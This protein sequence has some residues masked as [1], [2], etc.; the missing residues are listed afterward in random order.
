MPLQF[1]NPIFLWGALAGAIPIL[2]H[3]IHR[4][5]TRTVRFAMLDFILHSQKKIARKFH[6]KE[7]VLLAI[8]T[9]LVLGLVGLGAHP[10]LSGT[11]DPALSGGGPTHLVVILDSSMSMSFVEGGKERLSTAKEWAKERLRSLRRTQVAVLSTEPTEQG[12]PEFQ[13][14]PSALSALD[15]VSPSHQVADILGAFRRAYGLLRSVSGGEKEILFLTDGA[16]T[17]W[18]PFSVGNLKAVDPDVRVRLIRFGKKEADPNAAILSLRLKEERV[19]RGVAATLLVRVK[20]FGPQ[21]L[22]ELVLEL[23]AGGRKVGE[24]ALRLGPGGEEE[25]AFEA[26]F[27]EAGELAATVRLLSDPLAGDNTHHFVL[28]VREPPRVLVVDG[29]PRTSLLGSETFYLMNALAP[30]GVAEAPWFRVN[31]VTLEGLGREDLRG[32]DAVI[33][34]NA[35]EVPG[36]VRMALGEFVRGGGGLLF[37]LGERV[38]PEGYNRDFGGGEPDLLPG[39][40]LGLRERGG[41]SPGGVGEVAVRHPALRAFEGLGLEAFSGVRVWRYFALEEREG[42]QILLRLEG[43]SPLLMERSLGKGRVMVFA[44]TADRDWNDLCIR[45]PYL[46]FIQNLLLYLGCRACPGGELP[47][48]LAEGLRVGEVKEIT[49]AR[50]LAGQEVIVEGPEGLR[51]ALQLAPGEGD[52][53]A[54]AVFRGTERPGIYRVRWAQG[55]ASFSVNPPIEE[56]DLTPIGSEELKGKFGRLPMEGLWR[57]ELPEDY[58]PWRGMQRDLTSAFLWALLGLLGAEVLVAN[59]P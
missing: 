34:A 47:R 18:G 53:Q 32:Y 22:T 6:L 24:R 8:R 11:A 29:D 42:A 49:A 55:A 30:A 28:F 4:K 13:S 15:A 9:A 3:L 45:A 54:R 48:A 16:K 7:W 44:S 51:E 41:A 36:P 27:G 46:P 10:V 31:W 37:F 23:H 59:R 38:S 12:L 5:K 2:V 26:V 57:H 35:G 33:L 19:A 40:L 58:H 56:S 50:H 21:A 14:V 17:G 20:N 52:G 1:L 39:R 43:G 25:V